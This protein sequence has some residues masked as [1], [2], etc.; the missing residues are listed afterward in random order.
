MWSI[1]YIESANETVQTGAI[2]DFTKEEDHPGNDSLA[3]TEYY[4]EV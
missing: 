3:F 4:D 1:F 2:K